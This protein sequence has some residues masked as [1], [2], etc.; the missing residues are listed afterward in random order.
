MTYT[1]RPPCH[2]ETAKVLL[3]TNRD[4]L[5]DVGTRDT[6]YHGM[7][8]MWYPK[9]LGIGALW[10][11]S[12]SACAQMGPYALTDRPDDGLSVGGLAVS[13]QTVLV[14]TGILTRC[15]TPHSRMIASR[16]GSWGIHTPRDGLIWCP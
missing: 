10:H 16:R 14:H 11:T 7:R 4:R 12:R 13:G 15:I 6:Q 1:V 9:A 8:G 5:L 3:P 2:T